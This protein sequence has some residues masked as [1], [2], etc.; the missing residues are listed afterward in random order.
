MH[1]INRRCSLLV[2][3]TSLGADKWGRQYLRGKAEFTALN[4]LGV[5]CRMPNINQEV[6]LA[7]LLGVVDALS[8]LDTVS[9]GESAVI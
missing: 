1:P 2:F 3:Q 9:T 4:A 5:Q 7:A 8:E 6:D